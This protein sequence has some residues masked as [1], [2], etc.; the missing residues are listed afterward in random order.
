MYEDTPG[1]QVTRFAKN[2]ALAGNFLAFIHSPAR[3]AAFYN[4]TGDIPSDLPWHATQYK[5]PPTVS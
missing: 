1:F 2:K 3:M 5:T 4:E